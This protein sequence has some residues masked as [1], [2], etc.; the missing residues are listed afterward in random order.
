[1]I[2]KIKNFLFIHLLISLTLSCGIIAMFDANMIAFA[3]TIDITLDEG[4]NSREI[5][6]VKIETKTK[7]SEEF[8]K[9]NKLKEINNDNTE[10]INKDDNT[11]EINKDE[12]NLEKVE[13]TYYTNNQVYRP[14]KQGS[15]SEVGIH[16][17][18]NHNN[19]I[20]V[21]NTMVT[22][23]GRL[24]TFDDVRGEMNNVLKKGDVATRGDIDNPSH[25]KPIQVT[26]MSKDGTMHTQTMYKRDNGSL[27]D[28]VLDIWKTG[29]EYW[30]YQFGTN[31]SI[32][33]GMYTYSR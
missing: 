2:K 26:A 3:K 5:K 16:I 25:G 8:A 20:E 30:G 27:P 32:K 6:E 17:W 22:G 29:V 1:M 11:E 21:T 4:E 13:V 12:E 28:A 33:N 24:T 7:S 18:G 14:L 15:T 23:K 9:D 19:T 10:E 31:L